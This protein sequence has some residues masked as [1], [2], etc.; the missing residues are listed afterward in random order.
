MSDTLYA[1]N[2]FRTFNVIDDFNRECLLLKSILP[3]LVNDLS[4]FFLSDCAWSADCQVGSR[5]SEEARLHI[6]GD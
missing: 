4:G 6:L 2:R 5:G 1:G 3:S